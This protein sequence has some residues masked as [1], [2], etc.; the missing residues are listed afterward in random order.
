M[1]F[2]LK[3]MGDNNGNQLKFWDVYIPSDYSLFTFPTIT[4]GS[5]LQL[6]SA[7]CDVY[8]QFNEVID[9]KLKSKHINSHARTE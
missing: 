8:Q 9:Q 4:F 2:Y 5:K 1:K 6:V 7:A 3:I